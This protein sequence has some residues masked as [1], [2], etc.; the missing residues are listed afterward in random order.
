MPGVAR[1]ITLGGIN[2]S[3]FQDFTSSEVSKRTRQAVSG[4]DASHFL[5]L[6]CNGDV[7]GAPLL[8]KAGMTLLAAAVVK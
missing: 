6:R 7:R 1:R 5:S 4:I 3:T 2:L 8:C